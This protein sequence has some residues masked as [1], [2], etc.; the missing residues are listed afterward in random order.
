MQDLGA[1]SVVGALPQEKSKVAVEP[2]AYGR[3]GLREIAEVPLQ[4]TGCG[5]ECP[6]ANVWQN[7]ADVNRGQS[8]SNHN[9]RRTLASI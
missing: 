6:L 8:K 3:V 4:S 5:R 2:T 7:D 1:A 9:N